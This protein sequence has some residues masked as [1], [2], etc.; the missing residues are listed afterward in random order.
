MSDHHEDHHE[1]EARLAEIRK[2]I[3]NKKKELKELEEQEKLEHERREQRAKERAAAASN[4]NNEFPTRRHATTTPATTTT[5]NPAATPA[6]APVAVP[7]A[8]EE[9]K[10][11]QAEEEERKKQAAEEEKR[12]IEEATKIRREIR[13]RAQLDA[14]H[15]KD[16]IEQRRY[17]ESKLRGHHSEEEHKREHDAMFALHEHEREKAR[18]MPEENHWDELQNIFDAR[19]KQEK[20]AAAHKGA[21]LTEPEW[22]KGDFAWFCEDDK[23]II[24]KQHPNFKY[25]QVAEKLRS[26]WLHLPSHMKKMYEEKAQRDFARY[27]EERKNYDAHQ[28]INTS[29]LN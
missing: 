3:E 14:A 4:S 7:A 24:M 13:A 20:E 11:R 12:E 25:G 10:K 28:G 2:R 1:S 16:L 8:S 6:P 23:K 18:E 15:K 26:D 27:S 22:Y 29:E 9:E 19:E 5:T 17:E 21:Q